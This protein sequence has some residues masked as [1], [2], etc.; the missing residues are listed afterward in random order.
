MNRYPA[1]ALAAS[2][3]LA[4]PALALAA[5]ASASGG[6]S[7]P[8]TGMD[9]MLIGQDA[10]GS[11][12]ENRPGV[13]RKIQSGDL[14]KPYAT[15]S[16]SNAPGLVQRPDNA[17]PKVPD[18]FKVELVKSGMEGPRAMALAPNGDIFVADSAADRIDVLRMK[19]GQAKPVKDRSS[20][21]TA[22]TSPMAS[23][24]IRA[25]IPG[26]STSAMPAASSA[27]RTRPA[28]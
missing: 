19:D 4:L 26:G 13:W 2:A 27:F 5:G 10:F 22:S 23:P 11:W 18:G 9:N 21:A 1:I 8:D 28:T 25:T 20:P 3:I 12:Q 17:T 24:S 14:P 6:G 15:K 16:A 7:G